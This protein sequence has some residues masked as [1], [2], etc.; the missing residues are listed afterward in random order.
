MQ[1]TC[2]GHDPSLSRLGRTVS[3]FKLEINLNFASIPCETSD[4][5]STFYALLS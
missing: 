2:N 5:L 3:T 1:M 4:R